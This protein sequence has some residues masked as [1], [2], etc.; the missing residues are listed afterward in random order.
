MQ[1]WGHEAKRLIFFLAALTIVIW[2]IKTPTL[3]NLPV[4]GNFFKWWGDVFS[5]S[6]T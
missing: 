3:Q 5:K 4:V 2:G 6:T 1:G